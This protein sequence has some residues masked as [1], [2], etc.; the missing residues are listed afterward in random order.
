MVTD[1]YW[2]ITGEAGEGTLMTFSPDPA[3]NPAAK[4]I[5]D[6]FLAAGFKP[7]GYTLYTYGT[8][9]VFA[10]AAEKVG[11]TDL[12]KLLPVLKSEK[13]DTVLG[14]I[15]FDQKGDVTAPGYVL[16]RWTKG[17]YDYAN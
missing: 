15:G 16:Y 6:K 17:T 11:S 14:N 8:I 10:Q 5:V 12:D 4:P 9:Q 7:E 3:K 1:E 2:S 13:F